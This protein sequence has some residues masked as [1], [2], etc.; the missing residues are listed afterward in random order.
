MLLLGNLPIL[1]IATGALLLYFIIM[2][3][4]LLHA[5]I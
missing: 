2:L 3:H 4:A 1:V 5:S